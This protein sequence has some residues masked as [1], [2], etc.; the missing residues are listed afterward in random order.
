[1]KNIK[2]ILGGVLIILGFIST[3]CLREL[4]YL[5][6]NFSISLS[7]SVFNK[8]AVGDSISTQLFI[9][10]Y[11]DEPNY[12]ISFDY[13]EELGE[14]SFLGHQVS[15]NSE[16]SMKK[17]KDL[18]IKYNSKAVGH[19]TI[20]IIVSNKLVKENL[21]LLISSQANS[22]I[23]FPNFLFIESYSP[24][25]E[26][27]LEEELIIKSIGDKSNQY[28]IALQQEGEPKDIENLGLSI[29]L[30][31]KGGDHLVLK[32]EEQ[33][34]SISEEENKFQF[35]IK[36]KN[37][38]VAKFKL[39]ITDRYGKKFV[40]P[41]YTITFQSKGEIVFP[42]IGE[43]VIF[44]PNKS[45]P[46]PT[47]LLV[48]NL[49]DSQNTYKIHLETE[50]KNLYVYYLSSLKDPF[51]KTYL[52]I[53]NKKELKLIKGKGKF[54]FF[55]KRFEEGT[56]KFK[57]IITDRYGK[58]F[59]SPEYTVTFLSK[60]DIIFPK[61]SKDITFVPNKFT[62]LRNG[63]Q[64]N[65][66]GEEN[67]YKIRLET[68]DNALKVRLYSNGKDI[69][70]SLVKG[71]DLQLELNSNGKGEFIPS[72]NRSKEGTSKFKFIITDRY[73]KEF[74][75]PEYTVTFQNEIEVRFGIAL[76]SYTII[77][78][79]YSE[80]DDFEL[81]IKNFGDPS[82]KFNLSLEVYPE[83]LDGVGS[84][85]S[86]IKFETYLENKRS[87]ER[88]LLSLSNNSSKIETITQG[89]GAD[90]SKWILRIKCNKNKY[91]YKFRF[92]VKGGNK[93]F[94]SQYYDVVANSSSKV[95]Y[96]EV[97]TKKEYQAINKIISLDDFNFK[98]IGDGNPNNKYSIDVEYIGGMPENFDLFLDKGN[99]NLVRLSSFNEWD[100][101]YILNGNESKT[102]SLKAKTIKEQNV[103]FIIKIRDEEN[104][105]IF[106]SPEYN[107]DFKYKI[108]ARVCL[109]KEEIK[110]R[111]NKAEP[112]FDIVF[113]NKENKDLMF[114]R[115]WLEE[116]FP[117]ETVP[118]YIIKPTLKF[119]IDKECKESITKYSLLKTIS[120]YEESY[121][122][123]M[124]YEANG[125][126]IDKR[127]LSFNELQFSKG[128]DVKA[129]YMY[130]GIIGDTPS[131]NKLIWDYTKQI[132]YLTE[133]NNIS[134]LSILSDSNFKVVNNVEVVK[135][136]KR[137][138][139]ELL[140]RII[141]INVEKQ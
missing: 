17:I 136:E 97:Y 36:A 11:L 105:K 30:N 123:H 21:K 76:D 29:I 15:S 129:K 140:D 112:F 86:D 131:I 37:E 84:S 103:R 133:I 74:V 64:V 93:T 43:N 81:N 121:S 65:S 50:D 40:S 60:S 122:F 92:V 54:S 96:P 34:L 6:Y 61:Y 53:K 137:F 63:I 55:V 110:V 75:S 44:P 41:L 91:N 62:Y 79:V 51:K 1:M 28:K 78:N 26:I 128:K 46:L 130:V 2:L 126:G 23:K 12:K 111:I 87:K 5:D 90:I 22:L 70:N 27:K 56:S 99:N 52:D 135:Q 4:D 31:Y 89:N 138:G 83:S 118:F 82:L 8:V 113:S 49:E 77:P 45:N 32:E 134:K 95:E 66:L 104:G 71:E 117:K 124:E 38:G 68:K 116:N 14:L 10:Q 7:D 20:N 109:I 114:S 125:F 127:F 85:S 80:T 98:V 35:M 67:T 48:S 101:E 119:Y 132:V 107:I 58:E 73:G 9:K 94:Y 72:I 19:D 102:F 88:I 57:F 141:N 59:V 47:D 69:Y 16:M 108:Y 13:R 25:K 106:K 33:K 42:N 3:S 115:K 120:L 100:R 39:I 24:N 139:K 18:K